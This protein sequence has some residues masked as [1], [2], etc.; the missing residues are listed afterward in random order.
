[1]PSFFRFWSLPPP[2]G[3]S[4]SFP[5][6]S[7]GLW[8]SLT[9]CPHSPP[10]PQSC[11]FLESTCSLFPGL[12]PAV[13]SPIPASQQRA[14]WQLWLPPGDSSKFFRSNQHTFYESAP[15]HYRL[16]S[17]QLTHPF[18]LSGVTL[19]FFSFSFFFCRGA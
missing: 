3:L 19:L 6:V 15:P 1:M 14:S 17:S 11:I 8:G 10:G 12:W 2:T 4:V 7:A 9:L 18:L 13:P 5:G 16:W